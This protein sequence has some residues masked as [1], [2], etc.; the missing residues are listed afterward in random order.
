MVRERERRGSPRRR[1]RPRSINRERLDSNHCGKDAYT[2]RGKR[3]RSPDRRSRQQRSRSPPPSRR[4]NERKVVSVSPE[5]LKYRGDGHRGSL[6]LGRSEQRR[7]RDRGNRQQY[8]VSPRRPTRRRGPS[9]SPVSLRRDRA[10]SEQRRSRDRGN[11]QHYSVSPRRPTRRR[12]PSV[13]PVSLRRDRA[14]REVYRLTSRFLDDNRKRKNPS[15]LPRPR[16]KSPPIRSRPPLHARDKESLYKA[17]RSPGRP[18]RGS[19]PPYGRSKSYTTSSIGSSGGPRRIHSISDKDVR[20]P[21]VTG[22]VPKGRELSTTKGVAP[23]SNTNSMTVGKR[24]SA[25]PSGEERCRKESGG[26]KEDAG[27]EQEE[28]KQQVLSVHN[29][30]WGVVESGGNSWGDTAEKEDP[31]SRQAKGDDATVDV[32]KSGSKDEI[33]SSTT[34]GKELTSSSNSVVEEERQL[35]SA[36]TNGSDGGSGENEGLKQEEEG[37]KKDEQKKQQAIQPPLNVNDAG[38]GVV[39]L[40]GGNSWGVATTT[41]TTTITNKED[42]GKVLEITKEQDNNTVVAR[43]DDVGGERSERRNDGMLPSTENEASVSCDKMR[44]IPDDTAIKGNEEVEGEEGGGLEHNNKQNQQRQNHQLSLH[45]M[46]WGFV[47][48]GGHDWGNYNIAAEEKKNNRKVLKGEEETG[49]VKVAVISSYKGSNSSI[50]HPVHTT[51]AIPS[52]I[53]VSLSCSSI[54]NKNKQ[55]EED[56]Y[57]NGEQGGGG[58]RYNKDDVNLLMSSSLSSKRKENSQNL[59]KVNNLSYGKGGT[60]TPSLLSSKRPP[61]R[62]NRVKAETNSG[63][64]NG[65]SVRFGV[66]RGKGAV[67]PAW[68]TKGSSCSN[69]DKNSS[70]SSN[71]DISKLKRRRSSSRDRSRSPRS[72]GSDGRTTTSEQ[73][74]PSRGKVGSSSRWGERPRMA[75]PRDNRRNNNSSAIG[76]N[77]TRRSNNKDYYSPDHQFS[78]KVKIKTNENL[79]PSQSQDMVDGRK[80]AITTQRNVIKQGDPESTMP[81]WMSRKKEEKSSTTEVDSRIAQADGSSSSAVEGSSSAADM[82]LHDGDDNA[83]NTYLNDVMVV[84]LEKERKGLPSSWEVAISEVYIYIYI[85][86]IH[87]LLFSSLIYRYL[88]TVTMNGCFFPQK[89]KCLYFYNASTKETTWNSPTA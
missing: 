86:M 33:P 59:E 56:S 42:N 50:N 54:G 35:P 85:Y 3:K 12:G 39:E 61:L 74:R 1:S 16:G 75:A 19:P 87:L 82:G 53:K 9:V 30:G 40:M 34:E 81:A 76:G 14:S 46:G 2:G 49:E 78:K 13:S 77:E 70:S 44:H 23:L 73:R 72:R 26:L 51:I 62:S 68:M 65:S 83:K 80:E 88:T 45:D 79:Q 8:S 58:N 89:H 28:G 11:R 69:D 43:D 52:D 84:E 36:T 5:R 67:I 47:E 63:M 15:P 32:G 21:K 64:D 24:L 66:G 18:G 29:V 31:P 4:W 55:G 27:L 41:T 57:Q 60:T 7:S 17:P 38:W 37:V 71:S 10:R 6:G 20:R 48:A 25:A 22:G